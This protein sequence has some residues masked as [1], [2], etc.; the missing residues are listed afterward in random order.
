MISCE[1][2]LDPGDQDKIS[3]EVLSG[4][5]GSQSLPADTVY[6]I[7]TSGSTGVEGSVQGI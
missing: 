5:Q 1:P 4:S 3:I 6:I 7:K 2:E